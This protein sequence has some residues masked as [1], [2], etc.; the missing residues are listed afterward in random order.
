L[1]TNPEILQSNIFD[2]V[3]A[4][5]LANYEFTVEKELHALHLSLGFL[6]VLLHDVESVYNGGILRHV[7]GSHAKIAAVLTH[8]KGAGK[9][10]TKSGWTGVTP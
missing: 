4:V 2:T 3:D 5:E 8:T 9:M 6:K 7:I 1:D 10:D